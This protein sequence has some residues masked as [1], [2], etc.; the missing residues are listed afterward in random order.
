MIPYL[1]RM[2]F[3]SPILFTL[4]LSS[5]VAAQEGAEPKR[6]A[7]ASHA[8]DAYTAKDVAVV[9][10]D[11]FIEGA[12]KRPEGAG[13]KQHL[14]KPPMVQFDSKSDYFWHIKT[15]KG[16]IKVKLMPD[17]APMHVSSTIYLAR[18]GFYD[19]VSFHRVIQG[20]MAQGGCPIG[21]GTGGPGYKYAGEFDPKVKHDRPG[22]LSMANAG[23]GTDGSQFFLTFVPTPHLNGK[24]TIFGAVVGDGMKTVAAL[25]KSG[26]Q[27]GQTSE[28]LK[29]EQTWISVS[30]K[31]EAE[32]DEHGHGGEHGGE[33]GD[34]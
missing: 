4:A 8:D 29:M 32:G 2:H 21:Q 23:P 15:N 9:A 10:I 34:G 27:G 17:V 3:L 18:M 6:A 7:E 13:W 22:L 28:P 24:H 30:L 20:F 33:H 19:S 25:E 5:P 31:H 12:G 16:D 1:S 11:A 26:S 14:K